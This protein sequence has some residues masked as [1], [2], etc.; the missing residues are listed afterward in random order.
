MSVRL[1]DDLLAAMFEYVGFI[2]CFRE[3]SLKKRP[4]EEPSHIVIAGMSARAA[5]MVGIV[6]VRRNPLPGGHDFIQV[7]HS[8]LLMWC[9]VVTRCEWLMNS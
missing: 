6:S 5:T 1:R 2:I 3:V 4:S 8:D 7:V 9:H